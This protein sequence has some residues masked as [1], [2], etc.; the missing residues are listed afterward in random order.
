VAFDALDNG[1]RSCAN[2]KLLLRLSDELTAE[3]IDRLLRK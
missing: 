2:P 1:I 3:K